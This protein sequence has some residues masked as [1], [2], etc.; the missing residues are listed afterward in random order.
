MTGLPALLSKLLGN[1]PA[2][3]PVLTAQQRRQWDDHGFLV[4]PGFFE[5]DVADGLVADEEAFWQ[6]SRKAPSRVVIDLIGTSNARVHLHDAPIEAQAT[7]YKLN[8]L[9]LE[10][11]CVRRAVLDPQLVAI[12]TELLG[13]APLL[14]NTLTLKFGSEQDFHTDSL[15]MTPPTDLQLAASW[16]ALEDV[17]PD[18]GPLRYFPGS[19]KIEPYR[20]STGRMTAVDAEMEDYADYM[21]GQVRK[22]GLAEARFCPKKGDVFLWHSQ[23]FHG[24][25]PIENRDRTRRSL[26]AHYFRASDF[27]RRKVRVG[28][29]GYWMNRAHQTVPA[30]PATTH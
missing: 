13:G 4:L 6:G 23:L 27:L 3:A 7:R 19:H 18:A 28:S 30:R 25:A 5:P 29:G 11:E 22:L 9:Y 21:S 16:I 2:V 10:S 1:E 26:V 15:Y 20:F 8:D 17:S 24:G 12:V 14:C